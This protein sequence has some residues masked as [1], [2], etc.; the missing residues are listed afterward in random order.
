MICRQFVSKDFFEVQW[1][2]VIQVTAV[3]IPMFLLNLGAG[4]ESTR[5]TVSMCQR[6]AEVGADALLVVTPF[7][8]KGG[9]S[10]P[11]LSQ[12]FKQVADQSPVP[13]ILYSVPG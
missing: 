10:I 11:A 3:L 4:C 8:Y 7:Y 1:N 9:M 12:H 5:A 13:I 2:T 6:M